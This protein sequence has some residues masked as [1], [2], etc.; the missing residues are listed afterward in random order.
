MYKFYNPKGSVSLAIKWFI[1]REAIKSK[2]PKIPFW[3]QLDNGPNLSRGGGGLQRFGNV[4]NFY[5][6]LDLEASVREPNIFFTF[7]ILT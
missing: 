2:K 4:P 1:L 7:L 3:S 6:F 5:R